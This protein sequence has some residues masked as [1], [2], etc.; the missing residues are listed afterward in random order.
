MGQNNGD[1]RQQMVHGAVA[2]LP[3]AVGKGRGAERRFAKLPPLNLFRVFEAAARH[4]SFRNA[5]EELCVTPS[6]VSQQIRQLE[7]FLNV[8]LFR[9]LP[10]RVDLTR[11]GT[12][13]A[14]VVQ[15]TL[16]M[17]SQGCSRLVDPAMPTVLCLNASSSLA[18]RWLI[19]QLKQFMELHPQIKITLLAS[20]DPIDFRRQDIDLAIRWGNDSWS[21]DIHRE[22]L[23]SDSHFPVCSP[24]FC[25]REGL[26]T[27]AD[28]RDMTILHEV[29]GSAW[30]AWFEAAGM[31]PLPFHNVLYFSDASLMLEAAAQGQGVCLSNHILAGKDLDAGR[32]VR[33]FDI[34]VDLKTEGYYV[35]SSRDF[36]NRPAIA[37]L[38]EWLCRAAVR[39]VEQ[40]EA[41]L[42]GAARRMG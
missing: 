11:E 6:A 38:R 14:D 35:M 31:S 40:H 10:R 25:A 33:P 15:E 18:S 13:L 1:L 16:V 17:L 5:A 36:A 20:N 42:R 39:T 23:A 41:A 32:L 12:V 7:D 34:A 3:Y 24:E 27:P 21:D 37:T 29:N 19:P 30:A 22:L 26:R 9:R 28:L 2:S 8:R 4:R